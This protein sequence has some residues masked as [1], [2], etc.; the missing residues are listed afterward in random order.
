MVA[1]VPTAGEE[2]YI[3]TLVDYGLIGGLAR[4]KHV[5]VVGMLLF[6]EWGDNIVLNWSLLEPY[7]NEL[8]KTFGSE[9]AS[10]ALDFE[11]RQKRIGDN[12]PLKIK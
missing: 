5:P 7:Q 2:V 10:L 9:R 12:C 1:K 3:P 6:E 4:V 8:S 11:E